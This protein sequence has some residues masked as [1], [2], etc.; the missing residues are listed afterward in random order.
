[1]GLGGRGQTPHLSGVVN[2][3]AHPPPQDHLSDCS[4][5]TT[6]GSGKNPKIASSAAKRYRYRV[7]VLCHIQNAIH[8]PL[9]RWYAYRAAYRVSMTVLSTR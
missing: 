5:G 8:D 3:D 6:S 2:L 9:V 4:G 7:L 1:M